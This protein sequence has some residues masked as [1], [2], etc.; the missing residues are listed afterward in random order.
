MIF[1]L[2]GICPKQRLTHLLLTSL[3]PV[4][5]ESR[6]DW[7]SS[8]WFHTFHIVHLEEDLC[9]V[10]CCPKKISRWEFQYNPNVKIVNVIFQTF[11]YPKDFNKINIDWHGNVIKDGGLNDTKTIFFPWK[12]YSACRLTLKKIARI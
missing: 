8:F 2:L 12:I 10:L 1:G 7:N 6:S 11:I 4:H 5:R 9:K 3:S